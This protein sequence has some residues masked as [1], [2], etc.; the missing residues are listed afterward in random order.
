MSQRTWIEHPAARDE[1]LAEADRLPPD[2]AEQ[3]IDNVAAA[4]QDWMALK[5][6]NRPLLG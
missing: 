5:L 1:L 6:T 4:I 2:I 3:L